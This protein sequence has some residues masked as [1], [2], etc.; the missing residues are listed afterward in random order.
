MQSYRPN[1]GEL[2]S[3]HRPPKTSLWLILA[4]STPLLLIGALCT[5]LI[6]DS[7]TGVFSGSTASP[8][9]VSN[10]FICMGG[11]GLLLVLLGSIFVSDY[12]A[13]SATRTVKL[14][15]YEDGFTYESQ[16]RIEVCRWDEIEEIKSTFMEVV[17]KAFR[18][19]VKVIRSIV[20]KDGT[21]ID[22]AK[23]LHLRRITDL[24]TAAKEKAG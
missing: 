5:V 17:S 9:G 14:T 13:W 15:I 11:V 19:R 18:G 12:R 24:I 7:F 1:L 6:V 23:T 4:L 8:S 20:K 21:V 10:Y 16:G 2:G 3:V 22:L